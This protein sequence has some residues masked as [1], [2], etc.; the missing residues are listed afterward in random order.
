M[1]VRFS[2]EHANLVGW[3]T[4]RDFAP[5]LSELDQF[6]WTELW[7]WHRRHRRNLGQNQGSSDSSGRE[8]R[9]PRV[10]AHVLQDFLEALPQSVVTSREENHSLLR[11]LV[12]LSREQMRP[13]V[14]NDSEGVVASPDVA[15]ILAPLRG[16][17]DV[18]FYFMPLGSYVS[19][20]SYRDST[21]YTMWLQCDDDRREAISRD[22][23]DPFPALRQLFTAGTYE[24][25]TVCWTWTGDMAVVPQNEAPTEQLLQMVRQ[26][27]PAHLWSE[28]KRLDR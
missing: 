9:A 22:L 23:L 14:G 27:P 7:Y 2:L 17:F 15:R 26:V 28:I 16:W 25:A 1:G 4:R 8:W 24:P 18:P 20:D 19:F 3:L 10:Q 6:P 13:I 5:P 21:D 11:D 12:E